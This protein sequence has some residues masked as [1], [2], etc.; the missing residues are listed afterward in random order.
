MLPLWAVM[1]PLLGMAQQPAQGGTGT[2]TGPDT[3]TI[4]LPYPLPEVLDPVQGQNQSGLYLNDPSNVTNNVEY[5]PQS[6]DYHID[7]RMGD[8]NFRN[9]TYMSFDEYQEYE[10]KQAIRNYWRER[11]ESES[12]GKRKPL[13]P[14][15]NIKSKLFETIFGGSTIDIKPQGSAELIFGVNVSKIKNP[16]LPANQQTNTTF[17]FDQNIQMNVIGKIGDKIQLGVNYNTN[18]GFDF[19]NQMKLE[20]TG[21]EDEIIKKI[22]LGNV[23]LPLTGTLI[24]GSQNLFGGKIALQ[25]GRLTVT[26]LFSQQRGQSQTVETQGGAQVTKFEVKGD[27]YEPNRHYFLSQFFRNNYDS[28]LAELP[29]VRS[30]VNVTRIEVWVTNNNLAGTQVDGTRHVL[31]FMDLGEVHNG[32]VP[33]VTDVDNEL[34]VQPGAGTVPSNAANGLYN[35]VLLYPGIRTIAGATAALA[36]LAAPG[37][38]F[39]NTRDYELLSNAQRLNASDYRLNAQLGYISLNRE[40]QPYEVLAVAYQYTYNGQVFQVGEFSTD[41]INGQD[42]LVVKL[43]KSTV[44]NPKTKMWDLM[45]KNVYNIGAYQLTREDFRLDVIYD[46]VTAGTKTNYIPEGAVNGKILLR[47]MNLDRLNTNNDPFPDGYFDFVEGI[48]VNSQQGRIYFPV[49][50]P[51]GSH[52]KGQFNLPS[53]DAIAAKY[54]YQQLYDSTRQAALNYPQLNRFILAGQY[55]G[56]GGGEISLGAM[57]IPQG[58]VTVTAGSTALV[59]NQDYTVDYTL[60]K[61]RIIN[62]SILASGQPIRAT[63]ESNSLFNIQQKTLGGV[64]LD[65]VVSKDLAFGATVLNLSERPLTQ[66]VNQG[67][68]PINNTI[69]GINGSYRTESRLLTKIIDKIPLIN[70]K[71]VSTIAVSGEFAHLIPGNARAITQGGISYLDDFEGSVNFIDLKAQQQWVH[72]STP[73]GQTNKLFKEGDLTNNIG[74]GMNRARI[75]WYIIDPLFFRNNSLTP[76]HI[77]AEDQSFDYAR[78]VIEQEIFPSRQPMLSGQQT[79]LP[80][81]DVA[82]YPSER[83]VYNYDA[84]GEVQVDSVTTRKVA[85]GVNPDGSLKNPA[86]RWGGI[87]RPITTSDF[88]QNNIEFLQ[89][90]MMD[91]FHADTSGDHAGG[92]LY[93]NLGNVSEDILRDGRFAYENGLPTGTNDAPTDTTAWGIVPSN[94]PIVTVFDNDPAAR[95]FQ[96]IGLDGMNDDQERE[97]FNSVYISKLNDKLAAGELTQAGY[98]KLV[99]DPSSDNFKFYRGDDLDA[100]ETQITDR[101]KPYNGLDGNSPTADQ[102]G[103]D[104][105]ASNTTQPNSEDINRNTTLDNGENYFQYRVSLRK[106]DLVVGRN[107]ITNE[108]LGQGDLANGNTISVKWYQFK[109]PIRI[110]DQQV[111]NIQDFRSIRFI[112]MFLRGFE[113]SVF[114]RFARLELVR[115]E[116]RRYLFSLQVPGEYM[117]ED[118]ANTTLFDISTVNIEENGTKDPVNYILPPGIYRQSVANSGTTQRQLNEQSLLLKTCGL[119]DGDSR[120]AF[121]YTQFDLRSYKRLKMFIH[122]EAIDPNVLNDG[123]VEVFVRMGPDFD[124]NYYEYTIPVKVTPPGNYGT[125]TTYT[126]DDQYDVWP[127]QNNLDILFDDLRNAKLERDRA[128]LSDPTVSITKPYEVAHGPS[129]NIYIKGNPNLANVKSMLIGI[130]NPKKIGPADGDDGLPKCVEIWV[131]ELRLTDFDNK[132]GWAATAQAQLQLADLANVNI[133]TTYKK[134]GFG[135]F[136]SKPSQ[137]LREDQLNYE[138]SGTVQLGKFIPKKFAVNAPMYLSFAEAYRTPEFN[139][140]NPDITMAATLEEVNAQPD[141]EAKKED[142]LRK[143]EGYEKRRS[144]NFTDLRK[145]RTAKGK[146]MPW[147]VSN[148]AFNYAYTEQ[149]MRDINYEYNETRTY[150]GGATYDYKP[151]IKPVQPFTKLPFSTKMVDLR[152][153]WHEER[154]KEQRALLDSLRKG[155]AKGGDIKE[156]QDEL[157]ARSAR[158]QRYE[159]WSRNFLR[160]GWLKPI[161]DF[162]F[163]YA[164]MQLG[165]RTDMDRRYTETQLRNTTDYQLKIDPTYQKSFLWNRQYTLKYDLTKAIK[166]SFDAFNYGRVDEPQ[167]PVD[168]NAPNW[169]HMRDSIWSNILKWGRTTQ[170][171]H[172]TNVNWTLPINKLPITEWITATAQYTANYTWN[173]G[174]LQYYQGPNGPYWDVNTFGNTIQNSQNWQLNGNANLNQVYS[175][176]PWIKDLNNRRANTNAK[177]SAKKATP[178]DGPAPADSTKKEKPEIGKALLRGFGRLITSLKTVNI[179]Y[180]ETNGT[181]LPGYRPKTDIMGMDINNDSIG[182]MPGL[183]PFLFGWQRKNPGGYDIR[184]E[185]TT[186]R[187]IST[188]TLQSTPLLETYS[189]NLNA[190]A[191]LEPFPGFKVDLTATRTYTESISEFFR[192]DEELDAPTIFNRTKTGNFSISTILI[193]TSFVGMNDDNSSPLFQQFRD[194]RLTIAQRLA[195]EYPTDL[196]TIDSTGF[197]EGYGPTQTDVLIPAFMAAYRGVDANTIDM[198]AFTAIPLPNWRVT[199]DGLSKIKFLKKLFKSVTVSHAYRSTYS[200]SSFNTNLLYRSITSTDPAPAATDIY[201]N[202][203]PQ[204]QINT[205][206]VTEQF[207]PLFSIDMQWN[208]SLLTRFEYKKSRNLSMNFTNTQLTEVL[209]EEYVIGMGYTIKNVKFPIKFG[210]Y[211]KRIVSDLKLQFDVAI[212]DNVTYIRKMIENID[213]ATAGQ[214]LISFKFNADY[215]VSERIN[216]RLFYDGSIN[217]PKVSSSYPTENHAVGLSLRF[218]LAQ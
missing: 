31:C 103:T 54:V 82:F 137:R 87:M 172:T 57:N 61:V 203:I 13:I 86:S 44:T 142:L 93:F 30:P 127:I 70:T 112:R 149:Y 145:A 53:E 18:A 37:T 11:T 3:N 208:N 68:E 55:K 21:D 116:W 111:G 1:M 179:T 196:A 2:A 211:T 104:F 157:D 185:A 58:S 130:R 78:Q 159:K 51:F 152:K 148:L 84:D 22:E 160:S 193:N 9:P 161:K 12:L 110:P 8:V 170:Y 186:G 14:S 213:Q 164:P 79:N 126:T 99:A 108:Q 218:T 204:L 67:D 134:F 101:Y 59:E 10:A 178:T 135:N 76:S 139:P 117:P 146:P 97:F 214:Q 158:K 109:L 64:H 182:N 94:L 46:N 41:G 169:D 4:Q 40:L 72:A 17:N 20:Y 162:N 200:V 95:P 190:R 120:A 176:I 43:L 129:N 75:A 89:F 45:M 165:V 105:Q 83:G 205:I 168:K 189:T 33:G 124:F 66:K 7:Q 39:V 74:Y 151:P 128:L 201:G 131:N 69:W 140:L 19:E 80:V 56:A 106:E 188:D 166:I 138:I 65:Y 212:R 195:S 107:Y 202:F 50:E 96:D 184:R 206:T 85:D 207:S 141:A 48:T 210:K 73:Q 6:G 42:A 24:N 191:N 174:A 36:P 16:A 100:A 114:C 60:G 47:T 28:Y 136:D 143:T 35:Q 29:L 26:G 81:F 156:V 125:A 23:S 98:D 92:D 199:Y 118:D 177:A 155:N 88:E 163:N 90:W 38:D 183:V 154:V 181:S 113:D 144:M 25:F 171:T 62:Q 32:S 198:S 15:L 122:A 217:N 180:S 5:D 121:K 77:D 215:V 173:S 132:G 194:N 34:F 153:A 123:D 63:F 27:N 167:G 197:P 133:A 91:P 115:G 175:K 216:L 150:K 119:K 209:S 147:D 187:W 52:L 71:E 102:S 192:W 49:I